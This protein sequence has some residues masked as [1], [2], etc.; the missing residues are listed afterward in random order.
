[1]TD[2]TVDNSPTAGVRRLI[3]KVCYLESTQPAPSF[4]KNGRPAGVTFPLTAVKLISMDDE[5]LG[6]FVPDDVDKPDGSGE[7]MFL[8]RSQFRSIREAP[9]KLLTGAR[10]IVIPGRGA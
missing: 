8:N 9:N 5:W 2:E 1:M 4:D 7:E 6:V 10:N 3:G